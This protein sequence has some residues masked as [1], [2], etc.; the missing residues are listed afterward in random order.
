M[1]PE[2]GP[3]MCIVPPGMADLGGDVF[4]STMLN[5]GCGGGL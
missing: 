3:T 2:Y 1:G 5:M 4:V